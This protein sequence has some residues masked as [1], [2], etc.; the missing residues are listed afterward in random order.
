[1]P[2]RPNTHPPSFPPIP[3]FE[4]L[5]EAMERLS[6]LLAMLDRRWVVLSCLWRDSVG[7]A[8]TME[9]LVKVSMEIVV[10]GVPSLLYGRSVGFL[11]MVT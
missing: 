6:L 10:D 8:V 5:E 3:S 11:P 4:L 9:E 1:M 2:Q 7:L